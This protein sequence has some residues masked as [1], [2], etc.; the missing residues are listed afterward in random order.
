MNLCP[1]CLAN[2]MPDVLAEIER[3]IKQAQMAKFVNWNLGRQSDCR[4]ANAVETALVELRDWCAAT[5]ARNAE[6]SERSVGK[7]PR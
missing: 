6:V 3:R 4:E 5:R 7:E 2:P 1:K